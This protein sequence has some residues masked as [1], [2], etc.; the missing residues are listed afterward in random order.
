[1][2]YKTIIGLLICC[3]FMPAF[4]DDYTQ[5]ADVQQFMASFAKKYPNYTLDVEQILR[6]GK[7]QQS[8]LDAIS[9]PAERVLTWR[10][11]RNIFLEPKRL[12]QGVEFWQQ[13]RK[14]IEQVAEEY[15]VEPEVFLAI[16]GVETRY[17]RLVGNYRVLDAL[18]TLGFDYPPRAKFFASELEQ[19]LLLLAEQQFDYQTVKGSYAGAMG[20]GQF[21]S[22]S[23]RHYAIDGDGDGKVDILT[24]VADA[25]A[26]VANYFVKHGWRYGE[27]I[28]ACLPK[29]AIDKKLLSAMPNPQKPHHL[30]ADLRKQG[31]IIPK[32]YEGEQKVTLMAFETEAGVEHCIGFENFYVISRYNHSHL[33]SMAVAQFSQL[34]RLH[35]EMP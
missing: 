34:L 14:I 22:S 23:Y 25:L 28:M 8:I 31:L 11:Y 16:L 6:S 3:F 18:L 7:R 32:Q 10:Q 30:I 24:N 26:S 13:H 1:M 27:P 33:Y 20:Y 35:V 2:K 9:K 29:Q 17:G 15:Q 21:I 5:R 12:A 4:A 19:F